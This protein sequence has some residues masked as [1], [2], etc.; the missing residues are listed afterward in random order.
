[1]DLILKGK[2]SEQWSVWIDALVGAG[3]ELEKRDFTDLDS[4][5]FAE[6]AGT[7]ILLDGMLPK[8][9]ALIS[10]VRLCHPEMRII[11]VIEVDSFAVYYEMTRQDC[12]AY[13][14]GPLSGDEFVENIRSVTEQLVEA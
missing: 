10:C 11:V 1:M 8:L 7:A 13:V 6:L 12:V 3:F 9:S 2:P 5:S 14:A 4:Q